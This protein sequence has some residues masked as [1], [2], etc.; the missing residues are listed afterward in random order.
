MED[1]PKKLWDE[2]EIKLASEENDEKIIVQFSDG[3]DLGISVI[4]EAGEWWP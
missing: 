2:T 3:C 1:I 4:I